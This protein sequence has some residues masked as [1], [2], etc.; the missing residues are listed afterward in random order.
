MSDNL[1]S[2]TDLLNILKEVQ[3]TPHAALERARMAEKKARDELEAFEQGNATHRRLTRKVSS[4]TS[5]RYTE[6]ARDRHEYAIALRKCRNAIRLDGVTAKTVKMVRD[7][8][9]KH[10]G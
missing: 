6:E 9:N 3:R 4:A 2:K 1:P 7:L 10:S 5:R 8:A